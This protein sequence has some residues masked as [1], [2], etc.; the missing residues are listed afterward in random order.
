MRCTGDPQT[1]HGLRKRPWTAIPSRK[2]VTFSGNITRFDAQSLRP[3]GQGFPRGA[4]QP[5]AFLERELG[6]EP[7][8][9]QARRV[10]DLIGVGIADAVEQ[11]W[12]RQRPLE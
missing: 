4:E 11:S 8:R 10:E 6:R 5:L 9:R 1:G 7:E 3:R 12:V 2:A